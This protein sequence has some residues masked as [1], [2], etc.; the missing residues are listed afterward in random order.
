M[1]SLFRS[2]LALGAFCFLADSVF[3]DIPNITA[4]VLPRTPGQIRGW[5]VVIAG[6]STSKHIDSISGLTML[7]VVTANGGHATTFK[8][9]ASMAEDTASADAQMMS[10]IGVIR[11]D[12][13]VAN[14]GTDTDGDIT[15]LRVD[16][17]G[18]LWAHVT[19]LDAG[20]TIGLEAGVN[21]VGTVGL[22][23]G[24]ASVG[25]VG[26]D[27]GVNS[28]GTVGLDA[29]V[30][31]IGSLTA[32]VASIGTVGLD[33]GVNS[34]GT[35][36][37]DAGVNAI[38]SLTAGVASIGTVG[39]DAGV[40]SVGTVGLDAGVNSVGTVGLDAGVNAIG[41]LTA[42]VAS[43]GTV[44]L[45]AGVASVGTVGLDA[46]VNSV[47][48]VGLD[49]G[50]NAI[51]SLTAGVASIGTVGLDAGVNSIG[52]LGANSGV[53]IGDVDV[54]S[55]P[56]LTMEVNRNDTAVRMTGT[57][58]DESADFDGGAGAGYTIAMFQSLSASHFIQGPLAITATST[59]SWIDMGIGK[60][61]WNKATIE[62]AQGTWVATIQVR[63][64][65]APTKPTDDTL[66]TQIGANITAPGFVG[67]DPLPRWLKVVVSG[68]TS[69]T[70]PHI[71][72]R[73][74]R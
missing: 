39:L 7:N 12:T 27:A 48:T 72:V 4:G 22:D 73:A 57:T 41:S 35:V 29:G 43:I 53:D 63:G 51:G 67:V 62:V 68:F 49:A 9:S 45:D 19:A 25:T 44:G 26:L 50:V 17:E 16:N 33:A 38:G 3:A 55:Q 40:A 61:A 8:E 37:L 66:G 24:V 15:G 42:G 21:S 58:Y 52:T 60:W 28:V 54:L 6:D 46:G 69:G 36:G 56:I 47:G 18:A 2:I 14:A 34:V 32:G 70:I 30:N 64:S 65:N 1:R 10:V 71:G 20:S 74:Q 5:A 23:A 11:D 31:A 13:L 59:G